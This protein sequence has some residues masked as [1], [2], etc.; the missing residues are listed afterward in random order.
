M[1]AP[2]QCIWPRQMETRFR[3]ARVPTRHRAT[4]PPSAGGAKTVSRRCA[5]VGRRRLSGAQAWLMPLVWR[6][7]SVRPRTGTAPLAHL[8][9]AGRTGRAT[10]LCRRCARSRLVRLGLERLHQH[11]RRHLVEGRDWAPSGVLDGVLKP[12]TAGM[13]PACGSGPRGWQTHG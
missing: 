11:A 3:A 12:R 9:I 4:F 6:G 2:A 7:W 1:P 8:G 13:L 10:A 5:V